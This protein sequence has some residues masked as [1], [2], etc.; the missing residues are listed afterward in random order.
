MKEKNVYLLSILTIYFICNFLSTPVYS[1]IPPFSHTNAGSD[2]IHAKKKHFFRS[3][4]A[5]MGFGSSDLSISFNQTYGNYTTSNKYGLTCGL[6]LESSFFDL[7]IGL[8]YIE[9]NFL[10]TSPHSLSQYGIDSN[11]YIVK[12]RYLS[13]PL[14]YDFLDITFNNVLK[15]TCGVG[16]YFAFLLSTNENSGLGIKKFD[17]GIDGRISAT[18]NLSKRIDPLIGLIYQYGGLNNMGATNYVNKIHSINFSFYAGL[19]IKF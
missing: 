2:S 4:D 17:F 11:S 13:I 3:L 18:Y 9:K 16:P 6:R 5:L 14:N 19:K 1:F 15:L 10:L 12:N 7:E 8:M